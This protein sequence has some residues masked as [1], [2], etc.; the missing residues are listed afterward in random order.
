MIRATILNNRTGDASSF[1]VSLSVDGNPVN[2]TE[3]SGLDAGESTVV[4]L[5]WT[6]SGTGDVE[7]CVTADCDL[8]VEE[9]DEGN[10]LLCENVTVLSF[11]HPCYNDTFDDETKI[12]GKV[13]LIV[14]GGDVELNNTTQGQGSITSVV[15]Q[16][17]LFYF[18]NWA[19]FN[20]NDTVP[21]ETNITYKILDASNNTIMSVVD[22]Q[23]IS[24][25]TQQSIRL[26]AE[27][28]TT[29]DSLTPVLHDWGVCWETGVVDLL[30]TDIETQPFYSNLTSLIDVVIANGGDSHSGRFDVVLYADD[31]EV[32]AAS[33]D[34][35][36]A[37]E[38]RT[39]T[40]GWT[41]VH[42]G[43]HN[44]T[45]IADYDNVT[46]ESD[47]TNN[48]LTEEVT[49]LPTNV[50]R[51]TFDPDSS[52]D[53][54]VAVDFM[55]SMHVVWQDDRDGNWEIYYK[56][57]DMN[58]SILVDDTRITNTSRSSI[59]PVVAIDS[60]G[61]ACIA[62]QEGTGDTYNDYHIYY[63][64]L[65]SSGS[66]LVGATRIEETA[67]WYE[68]VRLHGITIDS[69][70]NI[71]LLW[72]QYVTRM[73]SDWNKV[74][75]GR[76]DDTGSPLEDIICVGEVGGLKSL[77]SLYPSF[78]LDSSDNVHIAYSVRYKGIDCKCGPG[79]GGGYYY[80][81]HE[82]PYPDCLREIYYRKLGSD[83]TLH[84][85][86][87]LTDD[88][89]TFASFT[90]D[91]CV[92]TD[93]NVHVV[94]VNN[95]VT[96]N[97]TYMSYTY[98]GD[99]CMEE[100]GGYFDGNSRNLY[101]IKLDNDGETLIDGRQIT[102][103]N[104]TSGIVPRIDSSDEFIYLTWSDC[105]G[106]SDEVYYMTLKDSGEIDQ[107]QFIV[108]IDDGL[109]SKDSDI[110][111]GQYP[112]SAYIVWSDC[113]DSND[114]IYYCY[115]R[116]EMITIPANVTIKPETLNVTEGGNFTANITL[117]EG[118]NVSDVKY[119]TV[120]CEG[121]PALDWMIDNDTLIATFDTDDLREDLPTEAIELN[122]TGN[123][124]NYSV[125][126]NVTGEVDTGD[127]A[128]VVIFDGSDTVRVL[129][130][131]TSP[132][133]LAG[134]DPAP[135]ATGVFADTN[136]TV[137]VR[138]N[139]AGVDNNTITMKVNGADVTPVITGAGHD[140]MLMYDPPTDFDLAE[141][142][143]VSVNASD[144]A[145]P[146]SAMHSAYSFTIGIPDLIVYEIDAYHNDTGF[147]PYFN[148]S[149]EVDVTLKNIGNG[150]AG[151]F[152]VS[153]YVDSEFVGRQNVSDL[154]IGKYATVQF[155]WTPIGL[156]C[157]DG[158]SQQTYTLKAVADCDNDMFE[159][160][161]E[162]NESIVQE[163]A[164]WAGYS[165]DEHINAIAWHGM[166]HGGLHYTTGDGQYST[167]Y[168]PGD[169]VDIHYNITL[170]A[171]ASIEL[172]RLNVYYTWSKQVTTGVYPV[173]EVRITNT[174]D[175][176]VVP[177]NASYND[178]PCGSPTIAFEYPF[179]NYVYDLT[180]YITGNGSYT[181]NVKNVGPTDYSF[182]IAAPGIVILYEDDTK[183]EYEFW[184]L[185]GADLLE[186]GHR[187]GAGN[188]D[189]SECISNVTFAGSIDTGKV[190]NTTLGIV[191]AWGGVAWGA[192]WTSYYWFNDNYLGD[193]SM[194][195]GY[196]SLYERTIG[197]MS[198]Y[199]G[200]SNNA[201]VGANVSDVTSYIA[202]D[203]NTVSFGDDGDSMLAAN[204]FL[205]VE[206]G[207]VCGDVDGDGE[208][209][210]GDVGLLWPHVFFPEDYPLNC[211]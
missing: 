26:F 93:D 39:V 61:N 199:A 115:Q 58:G 69:S 203:D 92:D 28:T 81:D 174:S 168:D 114:E 95:N 162:N 154:R 30:P 36:P 172:A 120:E 2:K 52:K 27:L 83:G 156:D 178:R 127:T 51:V 19:L 38:N 99:P 5:F 13:N 35:I 191:S 122:V 206:Y 185:E 153:L 37:G 48:S 116:K 1:N 207:G 145:T 91:V 76:F 179:G 210:M 130:T 133:Y 64:K 43:D 123:E 33:I 16:P 200:A 34:D 11:E 149:N 3:V 183:P 59:A 90:P 167:L 82:C 166:L 85:V 157:E 173:M 15:I 111:A 21:T 135:N 71:H 186:G 193:G 140:Y 10:N 89:R 18:K 9:S 132:P 97:S 163:I 151:A 32:D 88:N 138:D 198:M 47:E 17:Y 101:Y 141:V 62:W 105:S 66:V 139:G 205:M 42:A 188:L 147:S 112:R 201:Q 14:S 78:A 142:V 155:K 144:L 73:P 49:V 190:K 102:F 96:Y 196:G 104:S 45:A 117:P 160:D 75:Y 189:L 72:E 171:G 55:G 152:N 137:H 165:A 6:P 136:I 44:L 56:K 65:D 79:F 148:L 60:T 12:A 41:P 68:Y 50:R 77:H 25:I 94:W 86:I 134:H 106:E 53:S 74:W 80:S 208:I 159:L 164:Y 70:G 63:T 54:S 128:L 107:E 194:L 187:P 22:G 158:G 98:G 131:D 109:N 126:M 181:V 24:G 110:A 103:D 211:R 202:S 46:V 161:E 57:L 20:V 31:A 177:I 182:C 67:Y 146:S 169:S 129:S 195:G 118:Y 124:L 108:S 184:I 170:P 23:D 176:Y 197:G 84:D 180:P 125:D 8:E 100:P 4:N 119:S 87:R 209:T 175:T 7:L 40:F 121:A 113:R 204:A 192:D 143:N 29:N 150:D